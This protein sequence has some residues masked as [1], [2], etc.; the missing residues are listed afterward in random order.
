MQVTAREL[1]LRLGRYLGA[2]QQGQTVRIT[3]RGRPIAEL[4][5][6][7]PAGDA[8]LAHLVAQGLASPGQGP[9]PPHQPA[10]AAQSGAA[11][12]LADRNAER[13]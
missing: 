9:L 5:P 3:L 10:P 11:L 13:P 7:G 8:R 2:V 12:I 1:K 4:R 6:L